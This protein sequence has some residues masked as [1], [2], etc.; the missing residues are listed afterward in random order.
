[1]RTAIYSLRDKLTSFYTPPFHAT[2]DV[3]AVRGIVS[4][5]NNE[6]AKRE[7]NNVALYPSEYELCRMA[8]FDDVEGVIFTESKIHVL[9]RC[10]TFAKDPRYFPEQS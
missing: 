8:S 2:H 1:M 6:Q 7:G 10:D 4:L 9:G 3:A 5:I